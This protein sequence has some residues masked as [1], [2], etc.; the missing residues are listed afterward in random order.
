MLKLPRIPAD[1]AVVEPKTGRPSRF[2]TRFWDQFATAI[3][4]QDAAQQVEIER[5]NDAIIL[6]NE[7]VVTLAQTVQDL[8]YAFTAIQGVYAAAQ[9]AQQAANVAQKTA[10]DAGGGGPQ[11]GSA[12]TSVSI[13]GSG[14]TNG[15]QVDLTSVLAGP[16]T[17]TGSGPQQDDLVS[18]TETEFPFNFRIVEIVGMVETL[19]FTGNAVA[20]EGMPATIVN[21]STSAVSAYT[22]AETSTGAV[23]YR[24]DVQRTGS[25]SL[26]DLQLYLF[27]RRG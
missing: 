1:Q 21:A 13:A 3:E 8:N 7:T 4:A 25:G 9:A 18:T 20:F 24:M 2:F 12:S 16:L 17:I 10:D 27:V 5:L 23:S 15:P 11:S 14:W 6:L 26:L 19:K 22:S